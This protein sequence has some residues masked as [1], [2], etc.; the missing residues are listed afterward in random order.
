MAVGKD[1]YLKHVLSQAILTLSEKKELAKL[2]QRWLSNVCK[3]DDIE[4]NEKFSLNFFATP[5]MFIGLFA[6]LCGLGVFAERY[7]DGFFVKKK[8]E[9]EKNKKERENENMGYLN[10][11][12]WTF[13]DV[14]EGYSR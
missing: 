14:R 9:K 11:S 13:N 8:L 10:T 2:E 12:A 1:S 3:T 5:F 6:C 4:A 7:A